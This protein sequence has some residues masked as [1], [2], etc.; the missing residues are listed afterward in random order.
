MA[1]GFFIALAPP[2]NRACVNTGKNWSYKSRQEYLGASHSRHKPCWNEPGQALLKKCRVINTVNFVN[3]P[4]PLPPH[5]ILP[6]WNCPNTWPIP[7]TT[8]TRKGG[9]G[10]SGPSA[11]WQRTQPRDQDQTNLTVNTP[12][13]P[14]QSPLEENMTCSY[15]KQR[16]P[17]FPLTWWIC[18]DLWCFRFALCNCPI[19]MWFAS[20]CESFHKHALFS[21]SMAFIFYNKI[22]RLKSIRILP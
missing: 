9:V 14:S 21:M 16:G 5:R 22:N 19:S 11:S 17:I 20:A 4:L 10:M 12:P 6:V 3:C 1:L 15:L 18:F 8:R 13:R 2:V 7:I